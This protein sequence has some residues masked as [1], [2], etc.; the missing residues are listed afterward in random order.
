MTVDESKAL[1]KGAF[2]YW[3]SNAADGG[4]ITE[5]SWDAVTIAWNN[6]QV[7]RI[8]TETCERYS[9]RQQS[10]VRCNGS[11]TNLLL[12]ETANRPDLAAQPSPNSRQPSKIRELRCRQNA[13]REFLIFVIRPTNPVQTPRPRCFCELRQNRTGHYFFVIYRRVTY[14]QICRCRRTSVLFMQGPLRAYVACLRCHAPSAI[15][16]PKSVYG[17]NAIQTM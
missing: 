16:R 1:K 7:A 11:R 6:G 15:S 4:I 14:Q 8:S 10:R 3:R 2:A 13:C 9:E 17:G 12:P 5:T